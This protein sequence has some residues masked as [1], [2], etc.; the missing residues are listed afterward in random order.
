[1]YLTKDRNQADQPFDNHSKM[2]KENPKL[3]YC[4]KN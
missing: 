1:M 4:L 3:D 2:T